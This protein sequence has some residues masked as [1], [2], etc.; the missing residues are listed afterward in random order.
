[1]QTK[2]DVERLTEDIKEGLLQLSNTRVQI[3]NLKY[4]HHSLLVQCKV[5]FCPSAEYSTII[6]QKFTH[7]AA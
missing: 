7:F 4:E 5:T 2:D 1:L 3:E 6:N